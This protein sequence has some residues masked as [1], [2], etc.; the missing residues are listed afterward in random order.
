MRMP[1]LFGLSCQDITRLVSESMDH[2]LPL[3]QRIKVR[4]HLGMRKYCAR[5]AKQMHFL[6]KVCLT[7][8][9]PPVGSDPISRSAQPYPPGNSC[10]RTGTLRFFLPISP[11]QGQR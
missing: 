8:E 6:R 5:F 1:H 11:H 2:T 7:Y 9:A 3:T 4:I 10:V